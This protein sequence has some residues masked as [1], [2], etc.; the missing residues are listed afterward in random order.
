MPECSFVTGVDRGPRT[1]GLQRKPEEMEVKP[2]KG[3][4]GGSRIDVPLEDVVKAGVFL[5]VS[6]TPAAGPFLARPKMLHPRIQ[7]TAVVPNIK[8]V[9]V[10]LVCA[11]ARCCCVR[12]GFLPLLCPKVMP[13]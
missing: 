1:A 11:H 6:H 12:S 3:M 7:R 2:V 8:G 4:T 10:C 13:L 5:V 9:G